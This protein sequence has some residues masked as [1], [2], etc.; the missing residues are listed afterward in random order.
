MQTSVIVSIG[1]PWQG[2]GIEYRPASDDDATKYGGQ[3]YRVWHSDELVQFVPDLREAIAVSN[4]ITTYG[5]KVIDETYEQ[6]G[7]PP[8][9]WADI[10]QQKFMEESSG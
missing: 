4:L 9:S 5:V 10:V 7:G 1:K 3:P 2:T 8:S 6:L